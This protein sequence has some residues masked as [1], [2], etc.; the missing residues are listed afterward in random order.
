MKAELKVSAI[1]LAIYA[2]YLPIALWLGDGYTPTPKPPGQRIEPVLKIEHLTGF[3]YQAQ[4]FS[5]LKYADESEDSMRSPVILY[6]GLSPLG[7]GKSYIRD[8][9]GIGRGRFT[10]V[11]AKSDPRSLLFFS[12][13]DNSDPNTNGRKYWLVLP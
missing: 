1:G 5:L 11:K 3:A 10:F 8:V 6:E 13:S 9:L 4:S 7:P 12:T 2:V